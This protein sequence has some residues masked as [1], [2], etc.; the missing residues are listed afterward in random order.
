M[1]S[2]GCRGEPAP[3][4]QN[5]GRQSLRWWTPAPVV[6]RDAAWSMCYR[7][8]MQILVKPRPW[9]H[10]LAALCAIEGPA[11]RDRGPHLHGPIDQITTRAA[12][13]DRSAFGHLHSAP[14]LA[15]ASISRSNS[16]ANI[17]ELFGKLRKQLSLGLVCGKVADQR[18]LRR[19]RLRPFP[20]RQH[21]L[22]RSFF[23]VSWTHTC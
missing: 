7:S 10:R 19:I 13:I 5:P 23:G 6:M 14:A 21:V 17:S 4:C 8:P 3:A 1:T 22:H 2:N 9:M 15:W 12:E 16:N 11:G 18:A 20:A